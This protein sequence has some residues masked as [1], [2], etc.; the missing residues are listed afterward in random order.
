VHREA[1]AGR[2][3]VDLPERATGRN[4]SGYLHA[5]PPR[6]LDGPARPLLSCEAF[7]RGSDAAE[8]LIREL[9][10][11]ST[12]DT[13]ERSK[14]RAEQDVKRARP[15]KLLAIPR[16]EAQ[17]MCADCPMPWDKHG[18]VTPP[19]TPMPRLA[20][21]GCSTRARTAAWPMPRSIPTWRVESHS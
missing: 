1:F 19:P 17:D 6:C 11:K 16:L 14:L 18:W 5:T 12:A 15:E 13:A 4:L 8:Q 20:G 9:A 3:A 10:I 7:S 21:M 2:T